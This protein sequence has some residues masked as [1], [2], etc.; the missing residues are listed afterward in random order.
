MIKTLHISNYALIS[1]IDIELCPGLNIITG[2]TGAGKS[3]MLAA[4]GLLLGGRADMR[5]VRDSGR[6][7]VIE[8]TAL[9]DKVSGID[10][11]L[12]E[13]SL[14]AV[15]DGICIL[16][17]E[18]LPGG[19]SRA[20]INDTPVTLPVLKAV[21]LRLV[22]IHSQHQNLLLAHAAYQLSIIDSMADNAELRAQYTEAYKA[23]RKT[24]KQYTDM[25]EL[26][27]RSAA[28]AEYLQ[29]QLEQLDAMKLQ[30]GEQQQLERDRELL[31]NASTICTHLH[32]AL[33]PL[34]E[35]PDNA[36]E[37]LAE[38]ATHC[39]ALADV[40]DDGE[41]LAARLDS[42]RIEIQDIAESLT[43]FESHLN[44][45]PAMLEAV[46]E[47]LSALYS[48]EVKHHTDTVEGLIALREEIRT[49]LTA[50][51]GGEDS[52][53]RLEAVARGAK[54]TAMLLARELSD[55]RHAAAHDFAE[56]L[57]RRAVPLGMKNLRCEISLATGKLTPDGIDN[58]EFRFAFN[59]NQTPLPIG[60]TASG[61]EI[62][63]LMLCI[64]SIVAEHMQLPTVV[65]DE[66]D[67]GVSG[68]VAARMADMMLGLAGRLQVVAITHL[69][70]VAARGQAHFRVY[71]QDTDDATVTN[72]TRLSDQEREQEL[73]IM[74]SGRAD[75]PAALAAARSLMGKAQ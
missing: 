26:L 24:L 55:T 30:P 15:S 21:A 23:Y 41:Q 53:A 9:I 14:D 54:K 61:G 40:V 72:I 74:L 2:E 46:E 34:A 44:A 75:D 18:L 32:G 51:E 16:R 48:L 42:A 38:A 43:D 7:S 12:Q 59:K 73:A 60:G 19:R 70:A 71:K 65:F 63:R 17:R 28:D 67:T 47:R 49:K 58:A 8:A 25:R 33:G 29:Y 10:A 62:S 13:N 57:T 66:V 69:P 22:D 4:L 50:L 35:N 5:M 36:L 11:I 45:D 3:V 52:L 1:Q 68:D 39:R 64:K 37:A 31:A 6:K 20:F 27:R 56:E